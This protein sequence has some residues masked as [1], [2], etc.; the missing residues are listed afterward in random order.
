METEADVPTILKSLDFLPTFNRS[1]GLVVYD[2]PVLRVEFLIPEAGKG[3]E[4]PQDIKKLHIKAQGLRYLNFLAS[5]PR[6]IN[7]DDLRLCVPEPAVF[8][9]HK[10][11]ISARRIKKD[12]KERDVEAAQGILDY[13]YSKPEEVRRL[14]F[15]LRSVSNSWLKTIREV[16]DLHYPAL[17]HTIS[18]L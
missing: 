15:V 7:Y 11:I 13:L 3:F 6:P 5:Y 12:K 10:L 9:V 18:E 14:K 4:K 8:A 1:S 17:S 16:A 2:H